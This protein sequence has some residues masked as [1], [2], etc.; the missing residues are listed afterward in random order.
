[1]TSPPNPQQPWNGNRVLILID[2]S[3]DYS[4]NW[5][6]M[7]RVSKRKIDPEIEERIFEIFRDYIATLRD[8]EDIN[9]F[10]VSLLSFTEQ[11]M[12]AKR[13]AIAILLSRGYNYEEID[14]TL[15]V[16]KS[17]VGTVHK[18]IL[19]GA[20]GY[21]KAIDRISKKEKLESFWNNLEELMIKIS[22]PRRY[23]SASWQKKSKE[24]KDLAKRQRKL[25]A[26]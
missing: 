26:L 22:K 19:I 12:I 16:S 3:F 25:S 9:E 2:I 5:Y 17:T 18:Q 6:R 14:Q 24:G 10:F 7:G 11:V 4:N 1:M 23:S 13:L 21:N 15:K 20:L 8:P